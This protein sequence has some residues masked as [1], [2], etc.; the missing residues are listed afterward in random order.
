MEDRRNFARA[1]LQSALDRQKGLDP[2]VQ[3]AAAVLAQA[4]DDAR[5]GENA[6]ARRADVRA[7]FNSPLFD[8]IAAG[9]GQDPW[10]LRARLPHFEISNAP[11]PVRAL[12]PYWKHATKRAGE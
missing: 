9:L 1:R 8:L 12:H 5:A 11:A 6:G 3:L 2:F 7:F 10:V 4:L